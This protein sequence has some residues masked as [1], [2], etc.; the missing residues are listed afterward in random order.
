M[1]CRPPEIVSAGLIH[2]PEGRKLYPN[3]SVRENLELGA[4]ARARSRSRGAT[5][6]R[7]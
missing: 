7:F 1:A 4:Y 5:S 6:N 2:V 3:M